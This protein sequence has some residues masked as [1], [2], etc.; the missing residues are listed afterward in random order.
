[1]ERR[2]L[3]EA[4]A[5]GDDA[6]EVA[7]PHRGHHVRQRVRRPPGSRRSPRVGVRARALPNCTWRI[8]RPAM[9]TVFPSRRRSAGRRSGPGGC[10]QPPTELEDHAVDAGV[11]GRANSHERRLGRWRRLV[12]SRVRRCWKSGGGPGDEGDREQRDEQTRDPH[13]KPP[14]AGS[15]GRLHPAPGCPGRVAGQD[16]GTPTAASWANTT[17]RGSNARM[18]LH[19]RAR[20]GAGRRGRGRLLGRRVR[21]RTTPTPSRG[22]AGQDDRAVLALHDDR[23]VAVHVAR[24]GDDV[25]SGERSRSRRRAARTGVLEV[26]QLGDGVAAR[27]RGLELGRVGRRPADRELRVAADVVEVQVAVDHQR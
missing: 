10:R 12:R 25:D 5:V 18:P 3:G 21:R 4:D 11:V 22:P 26:D 24:R 9:R 1:M 13:E 27:P 2:L 16:R 20:P 8:A 23:L 15:V 17:R 19:P 7:G 6:L 14:Q